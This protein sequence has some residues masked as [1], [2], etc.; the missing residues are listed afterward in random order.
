MTMQ[1]RQF[2][3]QTRITP[4][5]TVL[6]DAS[7]TYINKQNHMMISAPTTVLK[8]SN[9][10]KRLIKWKDPPT[11]NTYWQV[12][13]LD[14]G[15]NRSINK[16]MDIKP[17]ALLQQTKVLKFDRARREPTVPPGSPVSSR[18]LEENV[19]TPRGSIF[20]KYT[21]GNTETP[22]TVRFSRA[23]YVCFSCDAGILVLKI[24]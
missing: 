5:S 3:R 6:S 7:S 2:H 10:S 21:G 22:K 19:V 23:R 8:S 24:S 17:I 12:I 1:R 14:K 20:T 9:D 11:G 16:A 15:D 4:A 13:E 18:G